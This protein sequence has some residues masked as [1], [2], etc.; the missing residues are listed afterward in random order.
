M[1]QLSAKKSTQQLLL[2]KIMADKLR[3]KVG[4]KV[5]AYFLGDSEVRA[6]PFT[7]KGIYQTN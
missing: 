5:F 2:S 7:V 3:L 4:D 6:R 1:P